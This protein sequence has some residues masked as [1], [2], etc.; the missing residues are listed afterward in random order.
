MV[1]CASAFPAN[2]TPHKP[3]AAQINAFDR[4]KPR[5]GGLEGFR[6][7]STAPKNYFPARGILKLD[8]G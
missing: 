8:F 1:A 7:V 5:R 2:M 4:E 3:I 6:S